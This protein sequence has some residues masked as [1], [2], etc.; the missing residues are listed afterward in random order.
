MVRLTDKLDT[1]MKQFK[2]KFGLTYAAQVYNAL[3]WYF[4][5]KGVLTLEDLRV[6]KTG[7]RKE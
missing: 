5:S 1:I 7:K 6:F 2:E 4:V 3:V